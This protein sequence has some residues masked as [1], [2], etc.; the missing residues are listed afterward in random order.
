MLQTACSTECLRHTDPVRIMRLGHL[1]VVDESQNLSGSFKIRGVQHQ[2]LHLA[3]TS[4]DRFVTFTSGSHGLALAHATPRASAVTVVMPIWSDSRKQRALRALGCR[5]IIAGSTATECE[6]IAA[7]LAHSEEA[8]FIH[9]YRSPH[10][11]GG[12]VDLWRQIAEAFPDGADVYVP[13]GS[14]GLLA[15]GVVVQLNGA[16]LHLIAVEAEPAAKLAVNLAA[17]REVPVIAESLVA[18]A[19]NVDLIPEPVRLLL[20]RSPALS[21][22]S[23]ADDEIAQANAY[24]SAK[25][26]VADPA[27]AAGFAAAFRSP[28]PL[29][30]ATQT[31]ILTGRGC[32]ELRAE[33]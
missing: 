25:E 4:P 5:L 11:I 31:V 13:V 29:R 23:V 9:P 16:P 32:G 6:Q 2:L 33:R 27:A 24:I 19:L 1:H 22:C 7:H 8:T 3:A 10:Q 28:A 18:S 14:G 12:Y 26:I 20:K 17:D 15:A 30:Y 21:I